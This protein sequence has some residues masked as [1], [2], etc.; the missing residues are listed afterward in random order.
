MASRNTETIKLLLLHE[1][2][3]EAE[4]ILNLMRNSGR[5]A[6]G[7]LIDNDDTL[8][9]AL[10]EAT[11][12]LMLL[13]PSNEDISALECLMHIKKMQKDIPAI[14]LINENNSDEITEG[15]HNGYQDVVPVEDDERLMLVIKRELDNLAER[16]LR[17]TIELSLKD[18]ERRCSLLLE[19]SRDAIT[20]VIDG[21]H[22][23]ANDSYLKLFGYDD[24]DDLEGMPI[25]DMVTPDNHEQF[26]IFLRHYNAGTNDANEFDCNVVCADNS[27]LQTRMFFSSASYDGEPCTQIMLRTNQAD[28]EL[29]ERLKEISSQDLLTGLFNRQ[30]FMLELDSVVEKA[31][32]NNQ[33]GVVLFIQL[34]NFSAIQSDVGVG[35]A[36]IVLSDVATLLKQFFD[37]GILARLNDDIFTVLINNCNL[38]EGQAQAESF[39][40]KIEDNLSE[41]QNRTIQI[42]T[43]IGIALIGENSGDSQTI[44]SH[45]QQACEQI[46]TENPL[47]NGVCAYEPASTHE[48]GVDETTKLLQSAIAKDQFKIL[49]QPVIDLRGDSGEIYEA[50]LRMLNPEGEEIS[51]DD[52][53]ATALHQGLCEQIDRWVIEESIKQLSE[54]RNNGHSSRV[55]INITGE[56]LR[57]QTLLPW[58][59]ATLKASRVPSDALV[60]QFT[61]TDATAYLKQAKDF[62]KGLAELHCKAAISRFGCSLN[63]FNNLKHLEVDYLKLD[64]SYTRDLNDEKSRE[65]LKELVTAAHAQGKLTIMPLI[66][67][68]SVLSVLWQIGV[69]YIQGYYLQEPTDKM[70]YDF[71]SGE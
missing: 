32:S 43:S 23:Y 37:G 38:D 6:R 70:N 31:I 63:P 67:S 5:A 49:F 10:S 14:L 19:S 52:F 3:D 59:S 69:N 9:T 64:G 2:R 36:D 34:D 8:I 30:H 7:Q 11:W 56:S 17:R 50:L 4:Q 15:L 53:L 13:R 61:E 47:G 18:A 48:D 58:L 71:S 66:E 35:G 26:K 60:F 40:S 55:M 21:M 25:L 24:V 39:R 65:N 68:A 44:V 27:Q 45:A 42:T 51:P 22:T 28:A 62:T 41:V 20:Y 1:S 12:D 54:H 57:D 46:K 29:Q 16:R 33:N